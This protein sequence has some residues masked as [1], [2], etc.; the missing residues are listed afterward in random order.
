MNQDI[1]S[2]LIGSFGYRSYYDSRSLD[3]DFLEYSDYTISPKKVELKFYY[4]KVPLYLTITDKAF[5]QE[6]VCTICHSSNCPHLVLGLRYVLDNYDD[7]KE[8]L[9]RADNM[10]D[11]KYNSFLFAKLSNNTNSQRKLLNSEIILK[12]ISE[13]NFE[14]IF[15]IGE[16]RKYTTK[17]NIEEFLKVYNNQNDVTE[18]EFGKDLTY[19]NALYY[20]NESDTEILDFMTLYVDNQPTSYTRGYYSY[21]EKVKG[22]FLKDK[23]LKQLLE[24]L[25]DKEFTLEYPDFKILCHGIDTYKLNVSLKKVDE[26]IEL[27]LENNILF[28]TG[29]YSYITDT[30]KLYK[31]NDE[32]KSLLQVMKSTNHTKLLFRENEYAK[33][34]NLILP[35]I[36]NENL[37]MDEEIKDKFIIANLEPNFYFDKSGSGIKADI[38][39]ISNDIEFNILD[40]YKPLEKKYFSRDLAKESSYINELTN[41]GFKLS[42]NRFKLE[43]E[44]S[45]IYFL[46]VGLKELTLKY[47]TFVSENI[48][49]ISIFQKPKVTS[50]FSIGRDNILK[51]DFSV[52]NINNEEITKLLDAIKYKKKYYKLKSGDFMSLENNEDLDGLANIVKDLDMSNKDLLNKNFYLPKYKSIHINSLKDEYGFI[53]VDKNFEALI[54]NFNKYKNLSIDLSKKDLDILRDY[55]ETG[56]KWMTTIAKCGFGGILAD[57]MGLGKSIQTIKYIK[58]KI[59]ENKEKR[60][61]L[62]VAPTSLIYNWQE[63][64][65][66]FGE[67]I[68]IC[69]INEAKNTRVMKIKSLED[70]D[71]VITT[72]GLLR[73]DIDEY[74]D[75]I[76]DTFIIDEA[77]NIKNL[78]SGITSVV[79]EINADTKFALTGTPIE[80]SIFELWSIFDFIMPGFLPNITKF[81]QIYNNKVIEEGSFGDLNKQIS[82]FILR[83][84]KKEVLKELP[85]KIENTVIVEMSE[86]QKKYYVAQLEITKKA[87]DEASNNNEYMKNQILILSLL[88]KLRQIC[89]DPHLLIEDY[90]GPS[91]KFDAIIDILNGVIANDHKVLLFSQFP[92]S[93]KLLMPYLRENNITYSFLDGQTKSKERMNLVDSFNSDKTNVFLISLKAG[94]TG[95]NLTAADIV[96]HLDPWWNPAVEN[97]ATDRAHRIGQ[98]NKVEVIKLICKGTIEERIIE[99]QKKKQNLSDNII[100]GEDRANIVLSKLSEKELRNILDI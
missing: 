96:I 57:E 80:N 76:F 61:F 49:K 28:V 47:P 79:K 7:F 11:A 83:R 14:L 25:K 48:K 91:A 98:V 60:L 73:Q 70:V 10:Y 63:E 38:K 6:A 39:L 84:K 54:D 24:I 13:A 68:K 59:K 58:L 62:I 97:Q 93:L 56:V 3:M 72:Y 40:E 66:K 34:S 43:D 95:L 78:N 82:P 67:N 2:S 27:E 55:Q 64:F 30:E 92:S 85:D 65:N 52:E 15:K 53:E 100:E 5:G 75:I 26:N 86:E 33:F 74:K 87:I 12:Y 71:V 88:T 1:E 90:D 94:G 77:Q 81:K 19:S 16:K 20:F 21:Y 45:I 18:L 69:I 4:K 31:V 36:K 51:Y 29:D 37:V 9:I 46:N 89:I 23:S 99:L 8:M 32:I 44:E 42:N 41:L 35:K 50:S 22:I 17:K